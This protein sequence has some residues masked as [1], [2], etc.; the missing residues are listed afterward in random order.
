MAGRIDQKLIVQQLGKCYMAN[1]Q[2]VF[3]NMTFEN[4]EQGMTVNSRVLLIDA[5]NLFIR[6]YAAVPSMDEE[7]NHIGGMQTQRQAI[8]AP[9]R[10]FVL[11]VHGTSKSG[12]YRCP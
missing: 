3:H 6:S 1:L 4:D 10:C 5:M 9:L 7:G 2:N 8:S 11:S 12:L